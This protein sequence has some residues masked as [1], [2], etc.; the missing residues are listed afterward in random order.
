VLA[1]H[2]ERRDHCSPTRHSRQPRLG[3]PMKNGISTVTKA[4]HLTTQLTMTHCASAPSPAVRAQRHTLSTMSQSTSQSSQQHLR[5][6]TSRSIE[7]CTRRA[8]RSQRR[9][10]LQLPLVLL[11]FLLLVSF[12]HMLVSACYECYK[13]METT[14]PIQ[15]CCYMGCS[16]F[17][18]PGGP[19]GGD[20]PAWEEFYDPCTVTWYDAHTAQQRHADQSMLAAGDTP[21][22]RRA[23][24]VV[25]CGDKWLGDSVSEFHRVS[26]RAI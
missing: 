1:Q 3:R 5:L 20:P 16:P 10:Q 18:C 17:V 13:C 11:S 4:T 7:R 6:P 19:P 15:C 24:C 14:G 23:D 2:E 22:N 12:T 8:T 25:G 21:Q 9:H 26:T